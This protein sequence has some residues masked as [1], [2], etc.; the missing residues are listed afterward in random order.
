M[1]Y[2]KAKTLTAAVLLFSFAN[3]GQGHAEAPRKEIHIIV[4]GGYTPN[5]IQVNEGEPVTLVFERREFTP[6]SQEVVFPSLNLRRALPPKQRVSVALPAL[7][8][9]EYEWK[10]GMN[11]LTGTITV[12][13]K[14]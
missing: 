11:M 10:C 4:D 13:K 2:K 6:C 12:E 7:R 14:P 9:G 1:D 8:V 5:R 3:M